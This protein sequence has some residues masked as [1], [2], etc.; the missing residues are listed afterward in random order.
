M[1]MCLQEVFR[2]PASIA[3][4][5]LQDWIEWGLRWRLEPM[6]EVAQML[7]NHYKGIIKWFT[8]QLNNRLL[9]GVN[10][11]IHVAKRKAHGYRSMD[12]LIAMIY[13]IGGKLNFNYP[14][15]K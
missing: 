6:V 4:I 9:E 1:K 10:S 14:T 8:S 2:Y 5:V 7:Q 12:D 11:L 13:L 3:L 15:V